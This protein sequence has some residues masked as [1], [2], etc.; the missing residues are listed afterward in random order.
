MDKQSLILAKKII[1]E[2]FEKDNTI[3]KIDKLEL[4]MNLWLYLNENTYEDNNK[5]LNKGRNIWK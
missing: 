1:L 4:I 2:A 3:N 5:T